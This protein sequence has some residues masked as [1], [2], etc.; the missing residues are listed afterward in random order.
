MLPSYRIE[1]KLE[2]GHKIPTCGYGRSEG[3]LVSIFYTQVSTPTCLQL[4]THKVAS[5]IFLLSVQPAPLGPGLHLLR[6]VGI[7]L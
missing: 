2:M 1:C 6:G 5:D 4:L 3:H 7:F